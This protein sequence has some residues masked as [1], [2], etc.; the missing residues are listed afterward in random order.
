[1]SNEYY[2]IYQEKNI[3]L[4][5]SLFIHSPLV[6]KTM[7]RLLEELGYSID[8]D[9]MTWKYYHNIAGEYHFRDVP[10]IVTSHD[11]LEEF[12]FTKENLLIHKGTYADYKSNANYARNLEALYPEQSILIRGILYPID[13]AVA[14]EANDGDI[15]GYNQDLVE[16]NEIDLL[17]ELQVWVTNFF[18]RRNVNRHALVDD[19][20]A[21]AF[22]IIIFLATFSD[23]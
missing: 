5:E 13:P 1:M 22:W 16:P 11:T 6:P 4:S 23:K 20:S 9:P 8:E 10:M 17:P 2:K 12:V 15:L 7:N 18:R 21:A 3:Q 19:L 14:I